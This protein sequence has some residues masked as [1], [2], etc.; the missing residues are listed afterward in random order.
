MQILTKSGRL[1][2]AILAGGSSL[3]VHAD[4]FTAITGDGSPLAPNNPHCLPPTCQPSAL[5]NNGVVDAD[6]CVDAGEVRHAGYCA[7][8]RKQNQVI[9]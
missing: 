5:G 8:R 2:V 4:T 3:L 1:V 6:F 7:G 9:G